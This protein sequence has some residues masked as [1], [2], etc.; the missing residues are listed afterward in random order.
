MEHM[1]HPLPSFFPLYPI[2]REPGSMEPKWPMRFV[3]V[4]KDTRTAHHLRIWRLISRE[5]VSFLEDPRKEKETTIY[6]V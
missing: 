3:S 1:D 4:M 2:P 5:F 6:C